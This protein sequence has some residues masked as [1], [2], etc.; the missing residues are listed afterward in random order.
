MR[1]KKI[2]KFVAPVLVLV[3]A[4][5]VVALLSATKP[6]PEKTTKDQRPVTLFVEEVSETDLALTVSTH[7]EIKPKVEIQLVPQVAGRIVAVSENFTRGGRVKAGETLIQIDDRDYRTAVV[8][9][10]AQVAQM[11]LRLLQAEGAA[12]VARRQWDS[13]VAGDPS[14][15]ALKEP[16]VDEARAALRSAEADLEMARTNLARTKVSVPFD[17]IVNEKL[18]DLGQFVGGG[19]PLGRVFSTSKVQVSL[20]LSDSQLSSLG[21]P[22]A[23]EAVPGEEPKVELSALVAGKVHHWKGKIVRTDGVV[24]ARSRMVFAIAEVDDPYGAGADGDM[25]LAIGLFVNADIEGR[26]MKKA[27]VLPRAALRSGDKVY[28]VTDGELDIRTVDVVYTD[29]DQIVVAEGVANGEQVVVS[30][31]RAPVSGMKVQ[32]LPRGMRPTLASA[33]K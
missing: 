10:E 23:F 13:K 14:A 16:Q 33:S 9:A 25:P 21:L 19:T 12:Q 29:V 1:T 20:A 5:A 24:D 22:I 27:H 17:G 30:S 26:D 7:G 2:L 4:A 28:V 31:V 3:G 11:Q 6:E 8:R 32:A 15:L 18:A